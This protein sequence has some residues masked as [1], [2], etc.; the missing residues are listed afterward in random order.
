MSDLS[1][2]PTAEA[3][4]G[5]SQMDRIVSTF[6]APTKT[7]EDIKK[8][9][10]SWWLPFV[11]YVLIGYAFF[12]V[13]NSKI[14]MRQIVENQIRISPKAE[15]RMSQLPADQR[16]K[17]MGISIAVTKGIFLGSPIMLLLMGLIISLVLWG[18]INF[19]FGG[20]AGFGSV[21]SVWMYAMLPSIIKSLLGIVMAFVGSAPEAF[22]IKNFAPTNAGA[23]LNPAE[24][25]AAVYS[26]LTSLDVISIWS[27]VLLAIGL[28]T[29][30]GVKRNAGYIA[31]FGWWVLIVIGSAGWAAIAG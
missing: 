30:A 14:G 5:M 1:A 8:G 29:V 23:F 12:G 28:A 10:K 16:E 27:M 24:T 3:T 15:E 26:L 18:T 6:T 22:N 13:I 4:P 25:N 2:Q 20:K 31:V 21:L 11:I 7:F 9:H 17:Q 19:A